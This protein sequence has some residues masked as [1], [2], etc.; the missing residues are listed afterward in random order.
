[1]KKRS[2]ETVKPIFVRSSLHFLIKRKAHQEGKSIKDFVEPVLNKA[3]V[4][5]VKNGKA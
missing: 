4:I 2:D 1:M 3:V 5:E